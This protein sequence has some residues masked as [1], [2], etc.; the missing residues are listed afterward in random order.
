MRLLQ[1]LIVVAFFVAGCGQA[2]LHLT[3]N[4]DPEGASIASSGKSFDSTPV[5]LRYNIPEEIRNGVRTFYP[6]VITA[7]WQDGTIL[8]QD[9]MR[10]HLTADCTY[11]WIFGHHYYY[12][13]TFTKPLPQPERA[14]TMGG[15][16]KKD[17][18]YGSVTIDSEPENCEVYAAGHFVGN[19]P[20]TLRLPEGG[21]LIEL[22]KAGYEAF[23]RDL[24][25]YPGS[26]TSLKPQLRR[27]N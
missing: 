16:E 13:Y 10:I 11:K 18:G 3:V 25:V 23:V 24:W 2:K 6:P 4:S 19:T 26:T 14:A 9:Q 12:E 7:I 20:M 21:Q 22:R 17:V 1:T 27:R 8:S 5:E 15:I